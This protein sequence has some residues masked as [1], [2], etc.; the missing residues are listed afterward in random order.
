[1]LVE[2]GLIALVL[3]LLLGSLLSF[4]TMI[5]AGQVAQ[6]VARLAALSRLREKE[7]AMGHMCPWASRA[8]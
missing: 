2:F 6:D 5:Q 3:Y 1:M 4:G 8:P 7:K